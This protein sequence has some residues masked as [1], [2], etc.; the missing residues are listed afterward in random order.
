MSWIEQNLTEYAESEA[1]EI[2]QCLWKF[3]QKSDSC[4][5][6]STRGFCDRLMEKLQEWEAEENEE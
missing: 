4:N 5:W 2:A 6:C 1:N 3:K